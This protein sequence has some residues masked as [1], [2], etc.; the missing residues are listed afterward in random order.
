MPLVDQ[1]RVRQEEPVLLAA[2]FRRLYDRK[3]HRVE[4]PD[5]HEVILARPLLLRGREE[6]AVEPDFLE[7]YDFGVLKRRRI[8]DLLEAREGSGRVVVPAPKSFAS[9]PWA[10]STDTILR[11]PL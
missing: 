11:R 8:L 6:V 1:A 9:S 7:P 5:G 2:L 3:L 10:L 4:V